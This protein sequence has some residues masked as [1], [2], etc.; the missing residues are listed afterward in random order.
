VGAGGTL[1]LSLVSRARPYARYVALTVAGLTTVL[2]LSL[3]WMESGVVIPSLW[4]PS[5][6]FGATLALDG[7]LIT[8]PLAFAL[9]LVACS[10]LLVEIGQ[11]DEEE[12]SPYLAATM[13]TLLAAGLMVLGAANVLTMVVGWAIYDLAQAAGILAAGGSERVAVRGLLF[14]SLAT[15]FLWGGV[16]LSDVGR[17]SELWP[18]MTPSDA[19]LTLWSLAGFIRLG[20]YPFHLSLPGDLDTS[21][22]LAVQLLLGPVVGWGLWL[23]LVLANGGYFPTAPWMLIVVALTFLVGGLLAWSCRATCCRLPWIGMGATGAVLLAAVLAGDGAPA[24][25][26][27]GGV[28]W[29]LG[30]AVVFLEGGVC[31]QALW[32]GVPALAGGLTLLGAPLTVGL[33]AEASLLGGVLQ[34]DLGGWGWRVAFFFL[35]NL[36]LASAIAR[37]LLEAC[38]LSFTGEGEHGQARVPDRHNTLVMPGIGLGLLLLPLVVVGLRPSLLVMEMQVPSLWRALAAPGLTGWLLWMASLVGG[39]MLAWQDV[40]RRMDTRSGMELLRGTVH[41]L[42]R[43]E[44]L[45]EVVV[46]ALDRGLGVLRA[47]DEVIGGAGAL[48]WS[49]LLF[50]LILLMWGGG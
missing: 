5:L 31:R 35:G 19:Q 50:L 42:L 48:L 1:G 10:A 11:P 36:F 46:G 13:L 20:T 25:L 22:P 44:W 38:A 40:A 17:G 39:G 4:Q 23:R 2:I 18:L 37:W 29:M 43:L 34:G 16:L 41:D 7:G 8:Y 33:M 12:A 47:A 6:L 32:W 9:A 15:L 27:T 14:G 26:A 28:A 45:S 49:L 30:V 24:V 21:V 3:R